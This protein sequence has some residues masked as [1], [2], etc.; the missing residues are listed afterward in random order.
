MRPVRLVA[1]AALLAAAPAAAQ[2]AGKRPL[3]PADFDGWRSI[4]NETLSR[5]G[6]WAVFSLVPQV[7]EG[8]VVVRSTRDGAEFR[9]PRGF[10]GRPQ[11]RAAATGPGAGYSAPPARFTADSRW[12]VFTVDPPRDSV[13]AA[14][15]ARRTGDRAPKS[16]LGILSLASGRVQ[17]VPRVK[18]FRLPEENGRW[19]A[20]LLEADSARRDSATAARPDSAA[21]PAA[22]ATPGGTPR[23]VSTDTARGA[24]KKK[25]AGST[26]VLR[27]L[28]TGAETRIEEV[29]TYAFDRGGDGW[30]T[31]CRRRTAPATASASIP[32]GTGEPMPF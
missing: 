32:W 22:A 19:L 20:Y 3:T 10:I 24:K 18:S 28:S 1:L 2:Q 27:D 12:V 4:R 8:E 26:L 21:A 11:T 16:G 30:P 29:A 14:R 9:H 31:R 15:R 17:T 7:G 6:A 23:P 13:E 25:D 5:D